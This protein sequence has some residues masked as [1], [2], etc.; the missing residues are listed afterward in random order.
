MNIKELLILLI[1]IS[2]GAT[3]LF[4]AF[5]L[6]S[7]VFSYDHSS[8]EFESRKG[9]LVVKLSTFTVYFKKTLETLW[10]R[11]CH[12]IKF[13]IHRF[14]VAPVLLDS[15]IYLDQIQA[16]WIVTIHNRCIISSGRRIFQ[17]WKTITFLAESIIFA[18]WNMIKLN[19]KS[20]ETYKILFIFNRIGHVK[21][22]RHIK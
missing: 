8:I 4:D 16:Y 11:S 15:Y 7:K 3:Q 19:H 18:L 17:L 20:R 12:I 6:W 10:N 21:F 13:R 5:R 1:K 2:V 14:I 22:I 9:F